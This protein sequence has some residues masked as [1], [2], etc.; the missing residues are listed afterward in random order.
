MSVAWVVGFLSA[1]T[2]GGLG[3]REGLMSLMLERVSRPEAALVLP[4]VA[5]L[6][7]L[8]IEVLLG[9]VGIVIGLRRRL[10]TGAS[11]GR[12]PPTAAG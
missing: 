4:L 8:V 3:V 7:C 12:R 2:P 5:R 10:F 6:L 9:V 11:P 1:L